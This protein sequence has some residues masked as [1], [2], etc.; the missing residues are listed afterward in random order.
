L[1][2]DMFSK[3]EV[4]QRTTGKAERLAKIAGLLCVAVCFLLTLALLAGCAPFGSATQTPEPGTPTVTPTPA[5]AT[6]GPLTETVILLHTN[7]LHGA[8]EPEETGRELGGLVNLVSLIDQ[9]RAE[10]PARTLLLD[11]GDTFQGTFVS[12][13]TQG[14]VVMEAMNLA[15]AWSLPVVT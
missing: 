10:D 1:E 6:G 12:N 11:A 2:Q 8:I 9:V 13:N 3:R 4:T 15:V 7:D 14:Q 5:G